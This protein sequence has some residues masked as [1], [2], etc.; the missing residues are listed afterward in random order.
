MSG[1]FSLSCTLFSRVARACAPWAR[2]AAVAP[3]T[4]SPPTAATPRQPAPQCRLR[5]GKR[6]S[7]AAACTRASRADVTGG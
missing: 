4:T 5:Y 3:S 6:D 1:R 7:C 2:P